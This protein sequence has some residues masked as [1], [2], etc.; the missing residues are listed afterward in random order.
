MPHRP[1]SPAFILAVVISC[2][3]LS[4]LI[5]WETAR[6]ARSFALDDIRLRSA[7]SL[8]LV[9][10]NLRGELEKYSFQPRLLSYSPVLIDA[11]KG[12]PSGPAVALANGELER[13]NLTTGALATYLMNADGLTIAASN[14][15]SDK[16]FVGKNFHFR[17]YFKNAIEGRLGR[18]FALGTTSG[19]RG[20]FFAYPVK[21]ATKTLGVVVVKMDV[22]R[23]ETGW[24]F[25]DD[26]ILVLDD[27]GVIFLSSKP[28]WRLK[29]F[30]PLEPKARERLVTARRYSDAPLEALAV[31]RRPDEEIVEVERKSAGTAAALPRKYLA[32]S[33]DMEEAGWRVMIL[34]DASGIATRVQI[35]LLVVGFMLASAVLASLN[36]YQRRRRLNE[37]LEMQ[38]EAKVSL[39]AKVDE[40]TKD[41]SLAVSQLQQEVSDRQRTEADLRRTQEELIQA[42]KLSALGRLSAGLSH[43]LNQPLTAIR[44]YAENARVFLN[45]Q[46]TATA[47]ANLGRIAEMSERMARI[48]RNLRTYA[49]NEPVGSRPTPLNQ[50]IRDAIVLL[51]PKIRAAGIDVDLDLADDGLNVIGGEVR[52]QQ[53]FMNLIANAI[54]AMVDAPKRKLSIKATHRD[55]GVVVSIRDTGPGIDPDVARR[56]FDPF[57]TTKE[58]G[59]GTG[60]GLSITYGIVKQFG[61]RI[62]VGNTPDSGAEFLV[63]LQP[64]HSSQEAAE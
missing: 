27:E 62:E 55:D 33:V 5:L 63:T 52:L 38:E 32:V 41:L 18:S 45:R 36:I 19:Q 14:W 28:D 44:N 20:Y 25:G 12:D 40:R 29:T 9:V 42:S 24:R 61:G 16:P 50:T 2:S 56:L 22:S 4:G 60:L 43:E 31:S 39:E 7:Y 53:V 59:Q 51:E 11:L 30:A 49:R 10:E 47:D 3:V 26:Q 6:R 48:I 57:F 1:L 21:D 58:V 17:P 46:D 35:A 15:S 13:T 23:L 8:D 54:D 64:A 37:R 34:A